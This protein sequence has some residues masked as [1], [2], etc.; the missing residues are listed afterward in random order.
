MSNASKILK[1]YQ[2]LSIQ[3]KLPEG[4]EVMNPYQDKTAFKLSKQFY[5]KFYGDNDP[6][7]LI[8]GINPGRFGG[9]ITGVPFTDPVKLEKI[10]IPN[11]LTK[12]V[13]LSANY[14]YAMIEAYGGPQKFY[15]QFYITALSPLGFVKD[16]KNLNYY[17]IKELQQAVEP[18]ML[19]CIRE[20]L[21]FG[22]N[23]ARCYC[24]GEGKNFDYLSAINKRY[25][26]F[27]EVIPLSHPRFIMQYKRKSV[28]VY[29][30]DY[31]RKLT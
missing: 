25:N 2:S 11:D 18:F 4:V 13:E 27:G 6:R 28:D 30:Q 3:A 20:Q 23:C 8:F 1:F 19:Q 16:G 31:L 9:G 26:F 5:E 14:I 21:D 17:D 7:T 10:G 24:L 22:V 29:I 12:K 15:H